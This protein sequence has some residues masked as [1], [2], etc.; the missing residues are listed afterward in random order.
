MI[1]LT[2]KNNNNRKTLIFKILK[3]K[4]QRKHVDHIYIPYEDYC[5]LF[6]DPQ[7]KEK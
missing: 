4:K 6:W 1:Y 2:R 5:C 3:K 7:E